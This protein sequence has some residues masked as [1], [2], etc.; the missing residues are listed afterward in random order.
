MRSY[1]NIYPGCNSTD[2]RYGYIVVNGNFVLNGSFYLIPGYPNYRG[3]NT[4]ILNPT[5]CTASDW[6]QFDTYASTD[7]ANALVDYFN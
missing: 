2:H 5:E 6:R 4:M 7:D 3:I 1:A